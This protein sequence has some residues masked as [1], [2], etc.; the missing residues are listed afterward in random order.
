MAQ[1]FEELYCWQQA[2]ELTNL[3]YTLTKKS[4]FR[5]FSLKDQICRAVVQ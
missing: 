2:R 3:I 4:T 1:S 5:D